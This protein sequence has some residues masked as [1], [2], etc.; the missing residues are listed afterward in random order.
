MCISF[1]DYKNL[2]RLRK[3]KE[4]LRKGTQSMTQIALAV[5]FDSSS[6]FSRIFKQYTGITPQEYRKNRRN[7]P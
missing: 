2:V 5:G 7:K 3:A 6:Y 1:T 4:I